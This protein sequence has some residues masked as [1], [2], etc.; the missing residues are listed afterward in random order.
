MCIPMK[1]LKLDR[2]IGEEEGQREGERESERERER[3]RQKEREKERE[4]ENARIRK[5]K[6]TQYENTRILWGLGPSA[7]LAGGARTASG[8][9]RRRRGAAEGPGGNTLGWNNTEILVKSPAY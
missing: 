5:Y 6:N 2:R 8:H 7:G 9:R 1:R 4:R 3:E